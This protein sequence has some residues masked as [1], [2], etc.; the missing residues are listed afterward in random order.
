[1]FSCLLLGTALLLGQAASEEKPAETPAPPASDRWLLMKALQGTWEGA[2]LDENR[3]SLSGWTDLSFT[4]SSDRHNQLPMGFNYI[5]N[6]FA[7]QQNW[8]RFERSVVTSGTSEPTFGFRS[9][10]LVGIDYRFTVA[11]GLFDSQLTASDGRP[12]RYGIDPVQFYGEAYFPTVGQGL[13]VKV[14][15]FFAQFGVESIATVDN[16]L[17]SHAYCFIYNP[18]TH[19]GLLT[20]TKLTRALSVQAGL[21][22]GSDVFIAPEDRPTFI[23]S[24]KW[25]DPSGRNSVQL[26]TIVGPGR[27]EQGK[28]FNNLDVFDLIYVH[29]IN[30]RL[31]TTV[32]SLF[33]FQTNV[34]GIGTATEAC[35]FMNYLTYRFTPRLSG[36]ARLEFFDD[37]QGQRTGFKGL[38]TDVTAG[39]SF[40]LR[41]SIIFRPEIR[42]DY[43]GQS[44]PFEN[45]HG[46]FTALADLILRW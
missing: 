6:D 36:T 29:Q 17:E 9:D 43:N 31:T 12:N 26:S 33:A 39:L 35:P 18:F 30:R 40:K 25:A 4:A 3:L 1:M 24:V 42:A 13:D 14:G 16:P 41:K 34:P 7:V 21:V 5:A 10:T 32:E 23:G 2:L 15:R 37:F 45:K 19:T 46:L 11:R 28:N 44:R 20:T 8:L 38:Y 27:F 22:L